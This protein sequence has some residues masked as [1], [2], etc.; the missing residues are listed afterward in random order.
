MST[1][2]GLGNMWRRIRRWAFLAVLGV[3]CLSDPSAGD[4]WEQSAWR[5][6]VYYRTTFSVEQDLA[7]VLHIAAVDSCVVYFNGKRLGAG[8]AWTRMT[9]YPVSIRAGL[10][11]IAVKVVNHGQG[12][13]SGLLV[14]V[15]ADTLPIVST[16]TGI[17][18]QTWYWKSGQRQNVAPIAGDLSLQT[19]FW[20]GE[21]RP[22]WLTEKLE[23]NPAWYIVQAGDMDLARVAMGGDQKVDIETGAA[24]V[25]AGFPGGIDLGGA[26]G[27]G[28]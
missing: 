16:K 4:T 15:S 1:V 7:G 2:L 28:G 18:L 13:G 26:A 3:L 10:D 23:K 12:N 19:W 17:G 14:A 5:S 20:T 22:N 25:V 27:G 8:D 9:T 21:E 11:T 6:V 24:E